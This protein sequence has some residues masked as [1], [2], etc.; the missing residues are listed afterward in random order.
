M[1]LVVRLSWSIPI[2]SCKACN[3]ANNMSLITINE[4]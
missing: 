3:A 2:S 1:H 4:A